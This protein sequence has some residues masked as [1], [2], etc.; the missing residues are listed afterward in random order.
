MQPT[1]QLEGQPLSH[2]GDTPCDTRPQSPPIPTYSLTRTLTCHRPHTRRRGAS[3]VGW[4]WARVTWAS[5]RSRPSTTRLLGLLLYLARRPH[6]HAPILGLDPKKPNTRAGAQ[7][8]RTL[9]PSTEVINYLRKSLYEGLRTLTPLKVVGEV[10]A[11][12]ARGI[13]PTE[14]A[15]APSPTGRGRGQPP[16]TWT[17]SAWSLLLIRG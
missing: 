13:A 6:P 11:Q 5:T 14:N 3:R 7:S 9:S 17:A 2:P 4:M 10:V 16:F 8:V 12:L 1:L 15:A